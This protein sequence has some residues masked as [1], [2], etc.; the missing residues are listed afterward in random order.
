VRTSRWAANRTTSYYEYDDRSALTARR[1]RQRPADNILGGARGDE[2]AH[3]W[4]GQDKRQQ[5]R[6]LLALV[7]GWVTEDFET[8]DLKDAKALIDELAS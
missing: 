7:C 5:A 8:L 2:H 3:F 1:R 6:D 4:R